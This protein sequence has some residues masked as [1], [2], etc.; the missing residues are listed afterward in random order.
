VPEVRNGEAFL[1]GIV[2]PVQA[3][4]PQP[5]KY[6]AVSRRVLEGMVPVLIPVPPRW[7]DRSIIATLF[8]K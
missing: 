3:A 7:L 4:L 6:K 2:D 5:G 1:E 8:P